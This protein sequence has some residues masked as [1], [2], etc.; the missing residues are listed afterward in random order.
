MYVGDEKYPVGPP[1]TVACERDVF[2][3]LGLEYKYP[4]ERNVYQTDWQYGTDALTEGPAASDNR[5]KAT[6]TKELLTKA[7]PQRQLSGTSR[8]SKGE[9]E[10]EED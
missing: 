10:T 8:S 2:S 6:D 7:A 5:L 4:W 1:V 3:F 9:S